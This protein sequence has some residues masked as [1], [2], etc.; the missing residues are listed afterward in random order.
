MVITVV[1]VL[2]EKAMDEIREGNK[3]FFAGI[4]SFGGKRVEF[5]VHRRQQVKL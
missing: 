5:Q 2:F 4:S 1:D 3:A